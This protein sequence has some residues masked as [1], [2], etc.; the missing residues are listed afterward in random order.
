MIKRLLTLTLFLICF[1]VHAATF[2]APDTF[3]ESNIQDWVTLELNMI[4]T[5][6]NNISINW[7][8]Y[9][10]YVYIGQHFIDTIKSLQKQG[11]AITL[12]LHKGSYSMHANVACYVNNLIFT[13]NSFLM[14]HPL[15]NAKGTVLRG[16]EEIKEVK[17]LLNP[18]IQKGILTEEDV[19]KIAFMYEVYVTKCGNKYCKDYEIDRRI[20]NGY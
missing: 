1:N 4:L 16:P 10:G 18:C 6:D 15:S 3:E 2:T 12:I 8:G 14:Y 17:E 13:H 20:I 19:K 11:K 5:P 7:S 9:G